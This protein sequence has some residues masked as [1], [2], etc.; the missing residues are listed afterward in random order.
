LCRNVTN[1]RIT[2]Q[3]HSCK[4]STSAWRSFTGEIMD[5]TSI[6]YREA[7]G[8]VRQGHSEG[9]WEGCAAVWEDFLEDVTGR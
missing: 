5:F 8:S 7:D 6:C 2:K 3:T 4:H 1:F 9:C